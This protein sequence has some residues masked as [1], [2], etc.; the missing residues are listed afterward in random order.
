MLKEIYERLALNL[1]L[2]TAFCSTDLSLLPRG[3]FSL[4][5]WAPRCLSFS[6]FHLWGV[7]SL[8]DHLKILA[9]LR[10]QVSTTPPPL[11]ISARTILIPFTGWWVLN[12][13]QQPRTYSWAIWRQD[14]VVSYT[15]KS[16]SITVK[17]I[18]RIKYKNGSTGLQLENHRGELSCPRQAHLKTVQTL[19][20]TDCYSS[21]H[22]LRTFQHGPNASMDVLGKDQISRAFWHESNVSRHFTQDQMTWTKY[23]WGHF[24]QN[25][26]SAIIDC[27]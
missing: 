12:V 18:N 4:A 6:F 16:H 7:P 19:W 2:P 20:L 27:L 10:A 5:S 13:C 22:I 14:H 9:C 23:L 25:Q 24:R 1:N 8:L 21:F 26:M 15:W 11:V 17:W 3:Q